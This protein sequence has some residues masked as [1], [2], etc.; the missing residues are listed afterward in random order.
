MKEMPEAD[1]ITT[2]A[3]ITR[4]LKELLWFGTSSWTRTGTPT[5]REEYNNTIRDLIGIDLRPA[6]QFPADLTSSGFKNSADSLFSATH[7]RDSFQ[8]RSK[9]P[10]KPSPSILSDK[11]I[12]PN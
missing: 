7:P 1:R 11:R 4:Y 10:Y 9:S 2:A 5:T 6:D 8:L 3:W 12:N